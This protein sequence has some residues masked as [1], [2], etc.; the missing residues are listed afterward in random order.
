MKCFLRPDVF[1]HPE[2][3]GFFL[4]EIYLVL[5]KVSFVV[6][7]CIYHFCSL[8]IKEKMQADLSQLSRVLSQPR[9]EKTSPTQWESSGWN[10]AQ[11][12][13]H[14]RYSLDFM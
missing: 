6:G 4:F 11:F 9:K 10:L 7:K 13:E 8:L 12:H 2:N 14:K 3:L 1:S 5:I